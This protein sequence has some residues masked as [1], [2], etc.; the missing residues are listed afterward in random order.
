VDDREQ[1]L[2]LRARDAVRD[3]LQARDRCGHLGEHARRGARRSRPANTCEPRAS[4]LNLPSVSQTLALLTA[5]TALLAAVGLFFALDKLPATRGG[6]IAIGLVVCA[7]PAL[8]STLGTSYAVTAS[9]STEFCLE[10]HEME[11]YG[12]SLFIDDR[13]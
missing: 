10:C 9:S 6:W 7:L 5:A 8:A 4:S 1:L 12:R 13:R 2:F 11:D 3:Q